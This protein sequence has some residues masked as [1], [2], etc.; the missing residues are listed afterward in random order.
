MSAIQNYN[1]TAL[2]EESQDCVIQLS[3]KKTLEGPKHQTGRIASRQMY[4]EEGLDISDTIKDWIPK[5]ERF[6]F[7]IVVVSFVVCLF[8]CFVGFFLQYL[9]YGN[10]DLS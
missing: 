5:M 1:N 7:D 4:S 3:L 9:S 2:L 6:T 10:S 8:V